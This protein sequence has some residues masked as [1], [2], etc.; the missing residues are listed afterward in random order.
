MKRGEM[1]PHEP[2]TLSPSFDWL[3]PSWS[4][5]G[6][7][8]SLSAL[9]Y[10]VANLPRCI[11]PWEFNGDDFS[12]G[13]FG[14]PELLGMPVYRCGKVATNYANN[15]EDDGDS[16]CDECVKDGAHITPRGVSELAYAPAVRAA[17][18]LLAEH[19]ISIPVLNW[20]DR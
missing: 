13:A 5:T 1:F 7:L 14:P 20:R 9:R 17:T 4:R 6:L 8:E 10:L 19:G 11:G 12:D 3:E 15:C 2:V 16:M 18:R